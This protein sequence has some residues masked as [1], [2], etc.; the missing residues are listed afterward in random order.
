MFGN[1]NLNAGLSQLQDLGGRFQKIKEDLEQN[2]ESSLRTNIAPSASGDEAGGVNAPAD[3]VAFG[4]DQF[5]M[6][7]SK[8][9]KVQ[10]FLSLRAAVHSAR[11]ARMPLCHVVNF[12]AHLACRM[13]RIQFAV[14]LYRQSPL[15]KGAEHRMAQPTRQYSYCSHVQLQQSHFALAKCL[16]LL[17]QQH[18]QEVHEAST[19]S[20]PSPVPD[21]EAAPEDST[22]DLSQQPEGS[23]TIHATTQPEAVAF[24]PDQVLAAH[25]ST[26]EHRS[27]DSEQQAQANTDQADDAAVNQH[28][29]DNE[30]LPQAK[31]DANQAGDSEA[32]EQVQDAVSDA[33]DTSEH[34]PD[35][36]GITIAHAAVKTEQPHAPASEADDHVESSPAQSESDDAAQQVAE[37]SQQH[38][39][40]QEQLPVSTLYM[41]DQV[42]QS[43]QRSLPDSARSAADS[44]QQPASPS[45]QDEA[46][47][48][49]GTEAQH[50]NGITH[51]MQQE[52]LE[53]QIG[54]QQSSQDS[55]EQQAAI[56]GTCTIF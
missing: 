42:D 50:V 10:H 17:L 22:Q 21:P 34:Q 30:Q 43:S 14:S 26:Q 46:A 5:L 39:D 41:A 33:A 2:I 12:D 18:E 6:W 38:E 53:Q 13:G 11:V 48:H 31:A 51:E 8:Q 19:S 20:T 54:S 45:G 7:A 16:L 44:R 29:I 23:V 55:H 24:Q 4:G 37:P 28:S 1:F 27:A 9:H 49:S 3:G 36:N 40:Q 35:S 32:L 25:D 52:E 15:C 47:S 56:P